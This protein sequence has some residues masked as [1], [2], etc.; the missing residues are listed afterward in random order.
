MQHFQNCKIQSILPDASRA[1]PPMPL[2]QPAFFTGTGTA[3]P[4]ACLKNC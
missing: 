2:L 3:P 1:F 4:H